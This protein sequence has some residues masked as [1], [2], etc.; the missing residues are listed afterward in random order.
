MYSNFRPSGSVI[1]PSLHAVQD[2]VVRPLDGSEDL[3]VSGAL[4][5]VHVLGDVAL[6][7]DA[8][9]CE[10]VDGHLGGQGLA[11]VGAYRDENAE[12]RCGE[13]PARDEAFDVAGT[14]LV[15]VEAGRGGHRW[16]FL[17]PGRSARVI[18]SRRW[19]LMGGAVASAAVM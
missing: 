15:L 16:A 4:Q 10:S 2:V 7:H 6:G 12:L 9:C 11:A 17:V 3:E 8:G 13:V 5:S 1:G 18:S 19:S 14:N